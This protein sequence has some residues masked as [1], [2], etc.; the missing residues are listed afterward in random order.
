MPAAILT[1]L[2]AG[3]ML[4]LQALF[5]ACP[6]RLLGSPLWAA[7]VSGAVT[8]VA[9]LVFGL[10]VTKGLPRT[11]GATELPWWAWAVGPCG[12]VALAGMTAAA[13]RLGVAAMIAMVVT[14]QVLFSLLLDRFGLF[15]LTASPL[16]PQRVLPAYLFLTGAILIR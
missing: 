16:T 6:G 1:A 8:T 4:P 15:G 12:V 5:N 3:A 13:P 10:I 9:L 2:L 14:G 11:A 7:C